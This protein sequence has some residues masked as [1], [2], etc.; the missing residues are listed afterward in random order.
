MHVNKIVH[1][2][3]NGS[4]TTLKNGIA[5]ITSKSVEDG[6][7]RILLGLDSIASHRNL[8]VQKSEPK[9][10]LTSLTEQFRETITKYFDSHNYQKQP[11]NKYFKNLD[12]FS[13]EELA[14]IDDK[15]V[16]ADFVLESLMA[17]VTVDDVVEL[18]SRNNKKYLK[19]WNDNPDRAIMLTTRL[20]SSDCSPQDIDFQK[21]FQKYIDENPAVW[22][23][24]VDSMIKLPSR[25][26]MA[27]I[28]NYKS[29]GFKELNRSIINGSLTPQQQQFSDTI[30]QMIDKHIIRKPMKLYRGEGLGIL[31]KVTASDGETLDLGKILGQARKEGNLDETVKKLLDKNLGVKQDAFMSTS[32]SDRFWGRNSLNWELDLEP[33]SKGVF[34]ETLPIAE[35]GREFE[36]LMQKGSKMK[37]QDI[38]LKEH[39]SGPQWYIKARLYN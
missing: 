8:I 23:M 3:L 35:G 14:E 30:S 2:L 1:T 25:E 21:N 28:M 19:F 27:A 13:D 11:D 38:K 7:E 34:L 24:A 29:V 9:D 16:A 12:Q 33:G 32:L 4:K 17:G 6:S 36:V 39:P 31:K 15:Y 26:Q 37:I 5:D 10:D 20:K 18:A 22:D